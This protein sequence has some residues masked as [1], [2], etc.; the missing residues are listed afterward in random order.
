MQAAN[1]APTAR[2]SPADQRSVVSATVRMDGRASSDP[3]GDVLAFSWSFT[4]VPIGSEL[5]DADLVWADA[6]GSTAIFSPDVIGPYVVGLVVD[7]GQFSSPR[8]EALV[9]VAAVRAPVCTDIIPDGKFFFRVISDYWQTVGEREMLPVIWSAYMQQAAGELLELFQVDYDKSIETIL[10][11]RQWRWVGYAPRLDLVAEENSIVFGSQQDGVLASTGAVGDPS[12]GYILS[13]TEFVVVEGA[14]RETLIGEELSILSGLNQGDYTISRV[15]SRKYAVAQDNLFPSPASSVLVSVLDMAT[16]ESSDR[17]RSASTNFSLVAGLEVGDYVHG[18]GNPRPLIIAGIGVADGMPDNSTLQLTE[19]LP[20]TGTGP[21]TV[22]DKVS[23]FIAPTTSPLT[24][25]VRVPLTEDDLSSLN[26]KDLVGYA[27][28]LSS[29][30]VITGKKFAFDALVGKS[31]TL[32]GGLNSGRYI[33][34]GVT[35]ARDGYVIT[36][37]FRGSF[38]QENVPFFLPPVTTADGRIILVNGKAYTLLRSYSDANQPAPPLGPGPVSMGVLNQ[39]RLPS[40]LEDVSWRVPATLTSLAQVDGA[41]IDFEE[42]GVRPGDLLVFDVE[43]LD[44]GRRAESTASVVGVDRNRLGFEIGVEAVLAGIRNEPSDEDKIELSEALAIPGASLDI[45]GALLLED[46]ALDIDTGLRSLLFESGFHDLPIWPSTEVTVAGHTFRISVK[47]IIRNSAIPVDPR[48]LSIPC[49]KEYV[50]PPVVAEAGGEFALITRD[51]TRVVRSYGPVSL[52]ENADYIIDAETDISGTDGV[53]AAGS[54][55][56][57]SVTGFFVSRSVD[58][59][60]TLVVADN[61]YTVIQ[62]LSETQVQAL[63]AGTGAAFTQALSSL[64]WSI[65]RTS[66]GRFIRFVSGLFGVKT[67]APDQLWGELTFIDNYEAI[68]KNFGLLV[69]LSKDDLTNR[70]TASTTYREAV[71][72]LM[73]AWA[74]GPKA[75]NLRLGAQILMGLPVADVKGQILDIDD[76]FA[77]APALGRILIEDLDKDTDLPT[78]LIRI[79]FFPPLASADLA[80]YSGLEINP[81]TGLLYQV[82]DVVERFAPLSK[83]IV[84]TDYVDTPEWWVGQHLQG[85]ASAEVRKFHTWTLKAAAGVINDEDFD[86]AVEFARTMDPMWT[87]VRPVLVL[88]LSDTIQIKD[89]LFFDIRE[90]L[91]DDPFGSIESTAKTNDFNGSGYNLNLVGVGPLSSRMLFYGE[92]LEIPVGAAPITVESP[93]GGFIDP[94]SVA[95]HPGFGVVPADHGTPMVRVNDLLYVPEGPNMGWYSV[96]VLVDDTH[97]TLTQQTALPLD[98]PLTTGMQAQSGANF[99]VFRLSQNPITAGSAAYTG[100]TDLFTDAAVCFFTEGVAVDDLLVFHDGAGRGVYTVVEVVDPGVGLY[101]WDTLRVTPDITAT[102]TSS[103]T[104]RRPSLEVNPLME[105]T[106]LV[107]TALTPNVVS[108]TGADFDLKQL[109]TY[110]ELEITNA[111]NAGIY[112]ILD[113]L[114]TA[115]P[116]EDLYV[117]PAVPNASGTNEFVIRRPSLSATVLQLGRVAQF[118]PLEELTITLMRP[119]TAVVSTLADVT[120]VVTALD[121]VAT[122]TVNEART[123]FTSAATNFEAAYVAGD[124]LEVGTLPALVAGDRN[125]GVWPVLSAALGV[126]TVQLELETSAIP[127][128]AR[129]L[130]DTADFTVTAGVVDS[131]IGGFVDVWTV[132]G[133][134]FEIFSGALAGTYVVAEIVTNNQVLLT[135]VSVGAG[136]VVAGRIYRLVR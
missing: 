117:R 129:L 89:E 134:H 127:T 133:D 57:G 85:D 119:R 63:D 17:I 4:S 27:S 62:V 132:P 128:M 16:T 102:D 15:V 106:K 66:P 56:F 130:R 2:I 126:V 60:D 121:L 19:T 115:P 124:V 123:E 52:S 70:N 68:E 86:L 83:G 24:D 11:E 81:A 5:S 22:Y 9:L 73:Y 101:P 71:L 58:I 114:T 131:A 37:A 48:V 18:L 136:Q 40:G 74:M 118:F 112:Q 7:D 103:Y 42:Q 64:P 135:D 49:L 76:A 75:A 45:H 36:G 33:I 13:P 44:N 8:A 113:V 98:S 82:G 51:G 108:L 34:A 38:P 59:G 54:S 116:G 20:T 65:R 99:F 29:R 122:R 92:D 6:V 53:T 23:G 77:S 95:P 79:Y 91:Y 104:I 12:S 28:L 39:Q 94:I 61:D 69:S 109:R 80:D 30:E 43:H 47:R 3:E 21:A 96:S 87:D 111:P 31:I 90:L 120:A 50:S 41:L 107:S 32:T 97:L 88:P 105:N 26:R 10:E 35:V 110:D 72:G 55:I 100:V 46:L 125:T 25:I 14:V 67:P 93:R 84:V 78:G 1:Q